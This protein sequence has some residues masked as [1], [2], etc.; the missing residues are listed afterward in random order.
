MTKAGGKDR[1]LFYAAVAGNLLGTFRQ[2][3]ERTRDVTQVSVTYSAQFFDLCR[4]LGKPGVATSVAE[5]AEEMSADGITVIMRPYPRGG[6]GLRFHAGML[7][8]A[9]AN[10]AEIRRRDPSDVI[11]MDGAGYWFPLAAVARGR[12]FFLSVHTILWRDE[13]RRL[14]KLI[15]RLEGRFIRRHCAGVLVVS[16]AIAQQV[17]KLAG[18]QGPPIRLFH[19]IYRADDFATMPPAQAGE[20]GFEIL[21]AGRIEAVKGVFDL[22]E[23]ARMLRARGYDDFHMTLCGEGAA[24]REL[25][26]RI[27]AAGLE[28]HIA[29]PG[30]LLRDQMIAQLAAA[31]CV[32]VPTRSSFPEGFNKVV[33][34]AVLAGRPV[35]T[36]RVCP[37]LEEVR[38]AAV[39]VEPDKAA[40]YADAIE[41]LMTDRA[42]FE[43]KIEAGFA[44]RA[45]FTDPAFGWE[46]QAETLLREQGGT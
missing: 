46:T 29:C 17:A 26:T 12:R 1:P 8:R 11:V 39:E 4:A 42:Q 41:R 13:P 27:A 23:V 7:A 32:V 35:V 40:G 44:L 22:V 25:R 18:G 30:H 21:Y 2:W 43:A 14:R 34:E 20:D 16:D 6:G 33:V 28:R 3:R 15:L 10:I 5:T 19:P 38:P 45:R 24:L 37:A 9:W 31:S 36:S